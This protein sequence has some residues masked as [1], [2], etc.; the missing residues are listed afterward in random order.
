M[1]HR[2]VISFSSLIGYVNNTYAQGTDSVK[3]QTLLGIEKYRATDT[4][5]EKQWGI[6]L[7]AAIMRGKQ[8]SKPLDGWSII[9]TPAAKKEAGTSGFKELKELATMAG[10][11]QISAALPKKSADETPKTLIIT[12]SSGDPSRERLEPSWRCF[13]HEIVGLSILRGKVEISSD[14][15][16]VPVTHNHDE[17]N[18]GRKRQRQ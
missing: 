16:L 13:S 12:G 9:F 5:K 7:Q 8:R 4:G 14:E 2:C 11:N 3:A 6:S 10:A 18:R 15:F 1:G 17:E